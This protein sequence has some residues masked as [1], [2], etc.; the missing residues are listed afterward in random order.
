MPDVYI[1]TERLIL[2]R[3]RLADVP[4]LFSFL[5]DP[6]AMRHTHVHASPRDC[7]RHIAGHEWQRRRR[8][9]GPWTVVTRTDGRIIGWGG[10]YDDPFDP[11][12]G[13]EVGYFFHPG[14]WGR[15][16][17]TEL[18]TACTDIADRVLRLP[19]LAAFA[20][21]DNVGSHRVLEKTGFEMIR[22]VPEM[23]RL[24]FRRLRRDAPTR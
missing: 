9:Y 18:V 11:G 10:L 13:P 19:V 12:W 5:G 20:H 6:E 17:A 15:G 23:H 3:P 14:A 21:P 24:L 16:F 1:E 22:F 2:R 7:L 8:G 4:A